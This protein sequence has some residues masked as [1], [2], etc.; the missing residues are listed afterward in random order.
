[1]IQYK[2][3]QCD[4]HYILHPQHVDV[5][6][7]QKTSLYHY[8]LE[9]NIMFRL[10]HYSYIG[11]P[12]KSLHKRTNEN[13]YCCLMVWSVPSMGELCVC[14]EEGIAADAQHNK[15]NGLRS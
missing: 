3:E 14:S 10:I 1:M 4:R 2:V 13:A 11:F 5:E 12:V 9:A 8:V 15:T 6:C 7:K